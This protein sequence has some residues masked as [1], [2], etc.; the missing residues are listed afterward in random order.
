[1]PRRYVS[2]PLRATATRYAVLWDLQWQIIECLTLAAGTDLAT[3]MS[4]AIARLQR[5]GWQAEGTP[6]Y[7]FCFV[8]RAGERCLLMITARD[9]A[10]TGRQTFSPFRA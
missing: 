6:D 5:A 1:M 10:E 3:S 8:H 7:G 9:P 4:T 2:Q